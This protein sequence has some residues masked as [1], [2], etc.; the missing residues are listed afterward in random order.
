MA[1]MG[2]LLWRRSAPVSSTRLFVVKGPPGTGTSDFCSAN[3][4]PPLTVAIAAIRAVLLTKRRLKWRR[5][6]ES[7]SIFTSSLVSFR[8]S[9]PSNL[10]GQFSNLKRLSLCFI[11]IVLKGKYCNFENGDGGGPERNHSRGRSSELPGSSA[12]PP[13]RQAVGGLGS[14][15]NPSRPA[16]ERVCRPPARP[17]RS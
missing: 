1:S 15:A 2:F 3:A 7:L 11:R 6:V 16:G 8:T 9:L 4:K 14:F 13:A 10:T 12:A 17:D 5:V